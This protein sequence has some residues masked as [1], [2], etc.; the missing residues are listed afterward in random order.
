M[1]KNGVRFREF[2]VN[3]KIKRGNLMVLDSLFLYILKLIFEFPYIT[4]VFYNSC[5]SPIDI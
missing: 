2:S 5:F 1:D 4:H 3:V